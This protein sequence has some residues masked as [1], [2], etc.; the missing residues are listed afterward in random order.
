[1]RSPPTGSSAG[2]SVASTFTHTSREK[3]VAGSKWGEKEE[4]IEEKK[5]EVKEGVEEGDK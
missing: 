5:E 3:K 4:K 2:T 1:M